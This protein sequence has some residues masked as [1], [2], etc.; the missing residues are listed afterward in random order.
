MVGTI[1]ESTTKKCLMKLVVTYW[2]KSLQWI[3]LPQYTFWKKKL[4]RSPKTWHF[5]YITIQ[6]YEGNRTKRYFTLIILNIHLIIL[7]FRIGM[8][9]TKSLVN[10]TKNNTENREG[11][12]TRKKTFGT[13]L[14]CT[15]TTIRLVPYL[16]TLI[17]FHYLILY[18][19]LLVVFV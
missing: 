14:N 3:L 13:V 5:F 12:I 15:R 16:L 19:I 7:K 2:K 18:L 6:L 1:I 10:F 9:F 17:F 8:Y 4:K 11:T